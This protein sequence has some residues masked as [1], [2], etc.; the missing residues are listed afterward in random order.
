RITRIL[1]AI[2]VCAGIL[3][4]V[5]LVMIGVLVLAQVVARTF[6]ATAPGAD[7]FA[8]YCL[9]AS[10]FLA[11]AYTLR[12]NAHIRVTLVLDRLEAGAR[13]ILEI[14]CLLVATAMTTFFA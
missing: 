12:H 9:S 5:F 11:L 14:W 1:D 13:R 3:A 7:Q 2:Y 10:S 6:G 4:G 8:G